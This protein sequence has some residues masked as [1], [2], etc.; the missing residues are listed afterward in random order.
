MACARGGEPEGLE[1]H[2]REMEETEASAT[3]SASSTISGK[4]ANVLR[5]TAL[6]RSGK[7]EELFALLERLQKEQEREDEPLQGGPGGAEAQKVEILYMNALVEALG[8]QGDLEKAEELFSTLPALTGSNPGSASYAALMAG[9][10]QRKN[11]RKCLGL[12][13]RMGAEGVPVDA[14]VRRALLGACRSEAQ[15]DEVYEALFSK[16]GNKKKKYAL[17]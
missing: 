14:A 2:L 12:L 11:L 9:P 15:E 16:Q 5:L 7:L 13:K 1:V 4:E 10:A 8:V 3:G 6:G 17:Y